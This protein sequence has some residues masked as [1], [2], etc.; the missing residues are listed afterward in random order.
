MAISLKEHAELAELV[1]KTV[2]HI[3]RSVL[4]PECWRDRS[5]LADD[6]RRDAARLAEIEGRAKSATSVP[7][8]EWTRSAFDSLRRELDQ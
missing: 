7:S 5:E 3:M 2:A 8:D 4:K 1:G 6:H